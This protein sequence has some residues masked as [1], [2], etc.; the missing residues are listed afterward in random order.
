LPSLLAFQNSHPEVDVL[1]V[2]VADKPEA[3]TQFLTTKR[4]TG[5]HVALSRAFP[6]D[7]PQN[8][9]TTFVVSQEHELA[10]LHESVPNDIEAELDADLAELNSH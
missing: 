7:M 5:L 2:D 4:L 1:A 6:D 8:Y 3:V 9:P 10:L